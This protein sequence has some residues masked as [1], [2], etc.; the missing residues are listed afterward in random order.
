[1]LA[2][3]VTKSVRL[4]IINLGLLAALLVAGAIA[5]AKLPVDAIPDVSTVQVTVL[6][7]AAG[8]SPEEM[9][10]R[11]TFPL[12]A[13]L[14]GLPRLTELR[15][16]SRSGL[17]AV[18]AAF[19]ER[20]DV[21]FARQ[22]VLERLR[23]V[24]QELPRNAERPQLAPVSTGLGEIFQFV[25]RSDQHSPSQLRTLLD[26]EVVPRLRGVPGVVEVN[27][28][29]GDLKQ[30]QVV[31]DPAKLHAYQLTLRD[32]RES[33]ERASP[34]VG[35][36]YLERHGES[37]AIRGA[38]VLRSEA[39]VAAVTLK[40]GAGGVPVLV[41][42]VG[43]VRVGAALRW[44]TVTRDGEGEVVTGIAMMLLG[45]N[46]KDVVTAVK[47]RVAEIARDL[48]PG[49]VIEPVYDR[50]DFV[51]RTLSTVLRNLLEGALVVGV[52]L[53]LF[54]G[55]IRGA[56]AVVVGIP[57]AMSVALIG[58]H[59]F[60]VTGDLMSLGA[61][62]FGFLVDGPI[63]M[64]EAV[65]AA[66]AG[67]KL[68]TRRRQ[69]A[70]GGILKQLAK[71][72]VFSVAIIMLVYLPLL[73]LEGV[74]GKMFRP[75]AITM[76][77]ALFGALV[78]SIFLFPPL[79]ATF[80]PPPARH[81]PRWLDRAADV[82]AGAL[83][84]ALPRR[85]P[86]A[87][88]SAALLAVSLVLLARGGADFVP[89]MEE[90]DAVVAIR[91]APSIG[92]EEAR[93]LDLAAERVVR[94][95]PE[96][97]TAV[98]MTGRAEVASDPLGNDSTE[99]L[100]RLRPK[101]QWKTARDLDGLSE[102]LK[103]AVEREVPGTFVSVSQ[104]IEDR[105]NELISGSRADVQI[106]VYGAD[107]AQLKQ[108]SE[109]VASVLRRVPGTGDVRVERLLGLPELTVEPD[110]ARLARHGVRAEDAL[111]VLEAA[112]VG[113]PVGQI[114]EGQRRFDLRLVLP[115]ASASA[116]GLG[117][118]FVDTAA[119]KVVPLAE[120]ASITEREGPAQIRREALSRTVRV[121]VNLRGRDLVSW[122]EEARKVVAAEVRLPSGYRLT[123][124]GQFENFER[125]SQRLAVVLPLALAIIFL[126]LL[127]MF[128]ES[129]YA[130]A[131]FVNVPLALI[132]GAVGLWLRELPFSV[133]AAVG[134]I[135]LAGVSVLNGVVISADVRRRMEDGSPPD[136]AVSLGARHNFRAVLT[137]A[138]VTA[139]GFLPMALATG[140]GAEVQRPLATVVIFGMAASVPLTLLVFPGVLRMWLRPEPAGGAS[141]R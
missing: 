10:Q 107:L 130:A 62:D 87:A 109:R 38:G 32:V 79:V 117:D 103:D 66:A 76:A 6:T 89:R 25:I 86:L 30:Y 23:G 141:A 94:R 5:A 98:A 63:I 136:T 41:R 58:M 112:R 67:Q 31:I 4:R 70:Y 83:A 120:V 116:D 52:I 127:A 126:M 46:S 134:F 9:E 115:P 33:L 113:T 132:G 12:E 80:V 122:V 11:V 135:A 44:G 29:G 78:F 45:A 47:A 54:L 22:L 7:Q 118:L 100:V 88:G 137:T 13:A 68:A 48:P 20:M 42:D 60:G 64:L 90:G 15:S 51:G 49:V 75:M 105:T 65:V 123:F 95:F 69:V 124:G 114:Y 102:A 96:T 121:D 28:M 39:D 139:C 14:N 18:T 1:M 36:G 74:E 61:I 84:W 24:E 43:Q 3:L 17:S 131:V 59:V 40:T 108:L 133:P 91:R 71:P 16:I 110:P 37:L 97:I 129:R 8:L 104:P 55:T 140:A 73:A 26:W 128:Q 125:A 93:R 2:R 56:V 34:M 138:A 57:A 35:G 72:V 53:A 101:A 21:W 77:C 82:Y 27:T 85:V 92:L 111:A 99:M 81:G 50:S 106:Q 119:G 19:E